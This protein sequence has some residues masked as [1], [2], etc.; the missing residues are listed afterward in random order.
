MLPKCYTGSL[1]PSAQ[2]KALP[3]KWRPGLRGTEE[4]EQAFKE[5]EATLPCTSLF[6]ASPPIPPLL[7]F[8][9][10]VEVSS[11]GWA[12]TLCSPRAL[13]RK[14]SLP[15]WHSLMTCN[16]LGHWCYEPKDIC[17]YSSFFL[18]LLLSITFMS[19]GV[20]LHVYIFLFI[21]IMVCDGYRCNV[22]CWTGDIWRSI[23]VLLWREG[24]LYF[25]KKKENK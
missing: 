10:E 8:T 25:V 3:K 4:D 2:I 23:G 20:W 9:M 14:P 7:L 17:K 11:E 18:T 19:A 13:L 24:G 15:S 16:A 5:H 21:Y 1:D 6:K 22:F 12:E